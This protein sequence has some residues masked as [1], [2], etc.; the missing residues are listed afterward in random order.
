MKASSLLEISNLNSFYGSSQI[1]F[2]LSPY[3]DAG[4]IVVILGR[5]GM[6]KTTLLYSI[7][8]LGRR[9]AAIFSS[10]ARK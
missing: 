10:E 5:N 9:C 7:A 1:I 8:N 4:E 6:G 3:V 2:D